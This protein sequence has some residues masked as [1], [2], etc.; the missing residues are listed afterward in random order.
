M[1]TYLKTI[2][3]MLCFGFS[4]NNVIAYSENPLIPDLIKNNFT[5]SEKLK[6]KQ[7]FSV[8]TSF[9]K[10]YSTS[11]GMFSNKFQYD[12]KSDL[13]ISGGI[14]LI[15]KSTNIPLPYQNDN[16]KLLYDVNLK[17][18]PWENTWIQLSISNLDPH[19]YRNN[20]FAK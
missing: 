5:N 13:L 20:I 6:I 7:E 3:L 12:F 16:F 18:Q 11:Y 10:N 15:Q 19:N 9:S 17:Y 14:H 8:G 1:K 4:Q 2:L